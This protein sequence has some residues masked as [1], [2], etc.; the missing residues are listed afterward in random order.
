LC[1]FVVFENF[2]QRIRNPANC[3]SV[4]RE[5]NDEG[6]GLDGGK[7]VE[8]FVGRRIVLENVAD[9]RSDPTRVF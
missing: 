3:F 1:F 4:V 9:G 5:R 2:Q 7:R 8:E 6:E